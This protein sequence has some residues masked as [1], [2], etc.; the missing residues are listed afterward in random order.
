MKY[1]KKILDQ[2]AL[3]ILKQHSFDFTSFPAAKAAST[4]TGDF[5]IKYVYD[6]LSLCIYSH[7]IDFESYS[8]LGRQLTEQYE[9]IHNREELKRRIEYG[10][11]F[12]F[13]MDYP[14]F[15]NMSI[16]KEERPDFILTNTKTIGIEITEFTTEEDSV[17]YKISKQNYGHGK[18]AAEIKQNA[19]KMHGPK[20]KKYTFNDHKGTT[21]ISSGTFNVLVKKR[22]YANE[23]IKKYD[24][25]RETMKSFDEFIILC[26]AQHTICISNKMD[27]DEVAE[28]VREN[29]PDAQDFTLAILRESSGKTI[30]DRYL[31]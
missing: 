13:M 8:Y 25:Y 28:I 21:I 10:I 2:L 4:I 16:S 7:N 15:E 24:S 9:A 11:L 14:E 31:F 22:I 26:D 5:P 17:L 29:R 3:E 6:R 20:A 18:S 23:V 1:D 27:S 30:V 12:H 19:L